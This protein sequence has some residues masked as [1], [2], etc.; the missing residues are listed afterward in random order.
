MFAFLERAIHLCNIWIIFFSI[1]SKK[2]RE[3]HIYEFTVCFLEIFTCF[4]FFDALN[5]PSVK[6]ML[7]GCIKLEG[8][9]DLSP[10]LQI[11]DFLWLLAE[12]QYLEVDIFKEQILQQYRISL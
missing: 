4:I 11:Q 10:E 2:G 7:I 6:P 9:Q 3:S 1:R 8:R 5:S 12:L